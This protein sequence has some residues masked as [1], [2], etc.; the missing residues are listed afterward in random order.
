MRG[1]NLFK[2]IGF[3]G[4]ALGGVGTLVSSWASD[5]EL[6]RLVDEKVQER[7]AA[8]EEEEES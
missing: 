1:T 5:K 8:K 7:L 2:L 6:E 3:L 4:M